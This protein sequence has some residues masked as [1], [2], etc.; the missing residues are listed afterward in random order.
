MG[1]SWVEQHCKNVTL[2]EATPQIQN[3]CHDTQTNEFCETWV[4][5]HWIVSFRSSDA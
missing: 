2:P 5:S 4:N 1:D 3:D